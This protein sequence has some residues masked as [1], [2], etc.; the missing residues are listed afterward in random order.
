MPTL[1]AAFFYVAL[2]L[3]GGSGPEF[4][5]VRAAGSTFEQ[6]RAESRLADLPDPVPPFLSPYYVEEIPVTSECFEVGP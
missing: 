1:G 3:G 2:Y 5:I 6:C 4:H